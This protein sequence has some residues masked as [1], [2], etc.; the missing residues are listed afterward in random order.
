MP[1]C[2]KLLEH[3]IRLAASRTFWTAGSKRPIR[4]AMMAMTTRSSISVKPRRRT[5]QKRLKGETPVHGTKG[6]PTGEA[7]QRACCP[8]TSFIAVGCQDGQSY[9]DVW[10]FTLRKARR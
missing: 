2:F 4:M 8:D 6:P 10:I 3:V 5:D 1:I 9:A 7:G